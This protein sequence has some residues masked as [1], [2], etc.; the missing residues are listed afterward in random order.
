M[1]TKS[2]LKMLTAKNEY[3]VH[4]IAGVVGILVI[5]LSVYLLFDHIDSLSNIGDYVGGVAGTIIAGVVLYYVKRSY[6][7]QM[8]AM[9]MQK[10]ELS[11]T[12]TLLKSQMFES[13][14]F[15][16]LEMLGTI[17]RD[18][19]NVAE[20]KFFESFAN[21][22]KS[23]YR[24]R[25]KRHDDKFLQFINLKI[26]EHKN[27]DMEPTEYVE[28]RAKAIEGFEISHTNGMAINM[29]DWVKESR[30]NYDLFVGWIFSYVYEL[31]NARSGHYF[32]HMYQI[33]KLVDRQFPDDDE[34]ETRK[35]YINLIS[36]QLNAH[37]LVMLFYNCLSDEGLS[38]SSGSGEQKF[39]KFVLDYRMINNANRN[40]LMHESHCERFYLFLTID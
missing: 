36:A 7:A 18:L 24:L 32:R 5:G 17:A 2:D 21:D 31:N 29:D 35:F 28:K 38:W 40:L 11:A 10:K 34:L 1:S 4:L 39:R 30:D 23:Y 6:D 20:G 14:F 16:M 8:R 3:Q 33:I 26:W 22:L 12:R 25:D 27:I 19:D 9:K 37:Q 15:N 13:T